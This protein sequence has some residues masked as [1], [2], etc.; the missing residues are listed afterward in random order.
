MVVLDIAICFGCQQMLEANSMWLLTMY[1]EVNQLA[2]A[3]ASR[4]SAIFDCVVVTKD[5]LEAAKQDS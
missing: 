3:K 5:M 4:S 2:A 1:A